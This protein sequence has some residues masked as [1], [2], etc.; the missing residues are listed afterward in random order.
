MDNERLQEIT[1]LMERERELEYHDIHVVEE[2]FDKLLTAL[3]AAGQQLAVVTA[4]RDALLE[5]CNSR[6]D[7]VE[8]L[9]AQLSKASLEK[10]ELLAC[11]NQEQGVN[12]QLHK[13]LEASQQELTEADAKNERLDNAIDSS[14]RGYKVQERRA[15]RKENRITELNKDIAD[16][17]KQLAEAEAEV[18]MLRKALAD[19]EELLIDEGYYVVDGENIMV[20]GHKHDPR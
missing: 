12:A 8:Q 18:V 4:N 1:S 16:L 9:R 2:C 15:N 17:R 5:I 11:V 20:K 7:D 13:Q 3:S 14:M 19:A 10:D 6:N